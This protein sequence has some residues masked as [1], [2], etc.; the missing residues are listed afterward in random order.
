M[1]KLT[2][3]P[4][5]SGPHT[6]FLL[7]ASVVPEFIYEAFASNVGHAVFAIT[8]SFVD[9]TTPPVF[10]HHDLTYIGEFA[11]ILIDRYDELVVHC[12][13]SYEDAY[14]YAH[15]CMVDHNNWLADVLNN[16]RGLKLLDVKKYIDEM[17]SINNNINHHNIVWISQKDHAHKQ[18]AT[19]IYRTNT[20]DLMVEYG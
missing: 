5:N 20:G 4:L 11:S 16:N 14:I 17:S 1:I 6:Q 18:C 12:F 15:S 19:K 13:R 7:G 9:N 3:C 10:V 8:T 2:F